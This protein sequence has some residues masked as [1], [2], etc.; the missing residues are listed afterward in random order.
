MNVLRFVSLSL[1]S[2]TLAAC[3]A[4]TTDDGGSSSAAQTTDA[5]EGAAV[6]EACATPLGHVRVHLPDA[7][8]ACDDH[9]V[10]T[11]NV[12]RDRKFEDW[13]CRVTLDPATCITSKV[14]TDVAVDG[15][16]RI[17]MN[18]KRYSRVVGPTQI[19]YW[20]QYENLDE[21]TRAP[22][23]LPVCASE[24]GFSVVVK[25]EIKD[26]MGVLRSCTS[27]PGRYRASYALAKGC[28]P[29]A[30]GVIVLD[31]S[32]VK[33]SEECVVTTDARTCSTTRH[34]TVHFVD[35]EDRFTQTYTSV[36]VDTDGTIV[37]ITSPKKTVN[38]ATGAVVA[39]TACDAEPSSFVYTKM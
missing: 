9:D 17:E 18:D 35:G 25:E 26:G 2:L 33:S 31:E 21:A 29:L 30:D 8:V 13:G 38:D 5:T 34:C 1:V 23:A 4:T 14:C 6:N 39:P 3:S 28:D 15:E 32:F 22:I 12:V 20:Y 24:S 11:F 27:A 37:G 10:S 16:R 19:N 7:K 36:T